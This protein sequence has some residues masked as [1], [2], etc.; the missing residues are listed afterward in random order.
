MRIPPSNTTTSSASAASATRQS[1][2]GER[3]QLTDRD[4]GEED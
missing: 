4:F 3:R 1:T 2:P